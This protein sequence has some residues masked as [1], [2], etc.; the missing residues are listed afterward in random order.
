MYQIFIKIY[1]QLKKFFNKKKLTI[2]FLVIYVFSYLFHSL[3]YI[4]QSSVF[5]EDPISNNNLV[6]IFVEENLYSKIEDEIEWYAVD[7]VQQNIDNGRAI[8]FPINTD[9]EDGMKAQDIVKVLENIYFDGLDWETSSLIWLVLIWDI[10]LP[11]VENAGFVFPSIYPYVDFEEQQYIYNWN[12]D[13]FVSNNNPKWQAEVWHGILNFDEVQEYKDY[14]LKLTDYQS[15][16]VNYIGKRFWYDDFVAIKKYF[17]EIDINTYINNFLFTEDLAYR[18][19]TN[20]LADTFK[21]NYMD[22]VSAVLWWL[23]DLTRT[24][25]ITDGWDIFWDFT[26]WVNNY[27][28]DVNSLIDEA[29]FDSIAWSQVPTLMLEW[30]VAEFLKT[31]D[32]L[33]NPNYLVQMRDNVEAGWR[34][35]EE[36]EDWSWRS[37]LDSHIEKISQKDA[38]IINDLDSQLQPLIVEF[39]N[40]LEEA[41]DLQV[42][43]EK[44]YMYV[45]IP[46]AY[47]FV[48]HEIQERELIPRVYTARRCEVMSDNIYRSFYFG[49]DATAIFEAEDLTTYRWTYRNY[50]YEEL[51]WLTL[52]DIQDGEIPLTDIANLDLQNKSVWWSYGVLSTQIEANRGYNIDSMIEEVWLYS[53]EKIHENYVEECA[54]WFKIIWIKIFCKW[55]EI[56]PDLWND[57]DDP[58]DDSP[59]ESMTDFAMR[60]RWWA[61]SVNLNQGLL[62][63][64]I[65]EFIEYDYTQAWKTIYDIGWSKAIDDSEYDANSV[66]AISSYA[67]LIKT[68]DRY[69]DYLY[70]KHIDDIE[71][72]G[73]QIID[74]EEIEF[75]SVYEDTSNRFADSKEIYLA[76]DGTGYEIETWNGDIMDEECNGEYN[77]QN[78]YRYKLIDSRQKNI[79]PTPEQLWWEVRSDY[80]E[81]GVVY[82]S[83]IRILDEISYVKSFLVDS[84]ENFERD[85]W[86]NDQI[87]SILDVVTQIDSD[88]Q[89]F[90]NESFSSST[91]DNVINSWETSLQDLISNS[92]INQMKDYADSA[93]ISLVWLESSLQNITLEGIYQRILFLD[94]NIP[95]L[96]DW[97]ADI[98]SALWW[99]ENNLSSLENAYNQ[100]T[101]SLFNSIDWITDVYSSLDSKRDHLNALISSWTYNI[102]CSNWEK[103]DDLCDVVLDLMDAVQDDSSFNILINDNNVDTTWDVKTLVSEFYQWNI[104]ELGNFFIMEDEELV[105]IFDVLNARFDIVYDD[106]ELEI[107]D[108]NLLLEELDVINDA[109]E[110]LK[111]M[112]MTPLTKDRPI[113]SP[114]YLTFQ[115]LS[116]DIVRFIYPNLYHV[117]VFYED[118][119]RQRLK[120]VNEIKEAIVDYLEKLVEEYNDK[121]SNQSVNKDRYYD[122]HKEWFDFLDNVES[123]VTPNRSY[124]LIDDDYLSSFFD[125][126]TINLIANLLYYQNV[127]W[128][129]KISNNEIVDDIKQ[130]RLDF[131]VN[132][133]IAYIMSEY[134]KKDNDHGAILSPSYRADWYEVAFIN[135]DGKDYIQIWAV[136]D[137]VAD[138]QLLRSKFLASQESQQIDPP[139]NFQEEL[140]NECNVS[141]QWT[142]PLMEWPEA[143]WC[144][145]QKTIEKPLE[146]TVDFRDVQG[147]VFGNFLSEFTGTFASYGESFEMYGDEWIE[148]FSFPD[149]DNTP[150]EDL[151]NFPQNEYDVESNIEY[152]D[153][154]NAL[155]EEQLLEND[156]WWMMQGDADNLQDVSSFTQAELVVN[157]SVVGD[158]DA[159]IEISST[160]NVWDVDLQIKV[161]GSDCLAI[162]NISD[163]L[164]EDPYFLDEINLYENPISQKI[165]LS[166]NIAWVSIVQIQLCLPGDDNTCLV[167][168]QQLITVPWEVDD[169]SF[170]IFFA[171]DV[172][173]QGASQ[174]VIVH[175]YDRFWNQIGQVLDEYEL[176]VDAGYFFVQWNILTWVSFNNFDKANYLYYAPQET[177]TANVSLHKIRWDTWNYIPPQESID[178]VDGQ[179]RVRYDGG[180]LEWWNI[181]EYS[182]PGVV[183]EL[184]YTDIHN[185]YQVDKNNIP[186]LTLSFLTEDL[187]P[188]DA[189]LTVKSK[190]W[191]F[192]IWEIQTKVRP[193]QFNWER[194]DVLQNSFVKKKSFHLRNGQIDIY[195]Y[196][197]FVAGEDIIT[198]EIPWLDLINI[199]V[200]IH[201]WPARVV[202]LTLDKESLKEWEEVFASL[203]IKDFRENVLDEDL[204][205]D[206][207]LAGSLEF[208]DWDQSMSLVV[209]DWIYSDLRILARDVGGA[210][211][212]TAYLDEDIS[213]LELQMPGFAEVLVQ[214]DILPT[215]DLNVM[216]LNLFGSDWW[217]QRWYFSENNKFVHNLMTWS[218]KLLAVTTQ[219]FEPNKLRA[220]DII[221]WEDAQISNFWN[222]DILFSNSIDWSYQIVFENLALMFFDS[223]FSLFQNSWTKISS[224]TEENIFTNSKDSIL[225]FPEIL[226]SFVTQNEVLDGKLIVNGEIIF[227][228]DQKYLHPDLIVSY[229]I[230]K[231]QWY[232][233]WDLVWWEYE[234]G[235]FILWT[236]S[237]TFINDGN[238]FSH[239]V[240][241]DEAYQKNIV[242][243]EGSSNGKKWIWFYLTDSALSSNVVWYDSIESSKDPTLWVGFLWDFKNITLFG[244]GKTVGEATLPYSSHALINIWDPLLKKIDINETVVDTDF[245]SGNGEIIY[246][247]TDKSIFKVLPIDFN[248]DGLED[249]IVAHT[250]WTIKILKNYWWEQA[251][252]PL[253]RLMLL[254]VGI[255]NIE[256]WDVD[257]NGYEDILIWT[258]QDSLRVYTNDKWIFDVDGYPVCLN[259]NTLPWEINEFPE[260]FSDV[261]QIYFEYMDEDIDDQDK[262]LDIVTNDKFGDVKIFYWWSIDGRANYLSTLKYT[263]DEHRY[264]GQNENTKLIKNYS[265]RINEDWSIVQDQS[266]IHWSW[267]EKPNPVP[268]S[269][270]D[271]DIPSNP[272]LVEQIWG[273]TDDMD[274]DG[275]SADEIMNHLMSEW[276]LGAANNFDA[277]EVVASSASDMIRYTYTPVPNIPYYENISLDKLYYVSLEHLEDSD[278]ILAYKVY[279]DL[280]GGVLLDGD[281]VKITITLESKEDNYF[282]YID[283]VLWPWT[284]EE[285]QNG[286][287]R[288][289][290]LLVY[291]YRW[292]IFLYDR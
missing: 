221:V 93:N 86:T 33:L 217:N 167:K 60:N 218:E 271:D 43:D 180:V 61:S 67:S 76:S 106:L 45:P 121:I 162:N 28:N 32:T 169:S 186:N 127:P 146:L 59:W 267:L 66:D 196:P 7:Y 188:L 47:Q 2:M 177:L 224:N 274:F 87:Q 222:K 109:D 145:L 288:L 112:S 65:Y 216:Y 107:I 5:A 201:P 50:S 92:Q 57:E 114:R 83:Y 98:D 38:W 108:I 174:P 134:L 193:V 236:D 220:I 242:F 265:T 197:N 135:S 245:D 3:I 25:E 268:A 91:S 1:E 191:N 247:S 275:M 111:S 181:L 290:S 208:A 226:D 258:T 24:G 153:Q 289:Y 157:N 11:V 165:K 213:P 160:R 214:K 39:N 168:T 90:L 194:I 154:W 41:V 237:D 23:N 219:L 18:R 176:R 280:D 89:W 279:E 155:L 52:D 256:V 128:E 281:E 292:L 82:N 215:E 164:C 46:T 147:P 40:M 276:P 64:N 253:Q 95:L 118:N 264:V 159:S 80:I 116:W 77:I 132:A 171:M 291:C 250:D 97:L 166:N 55:K 223:N 9:S 184:A 235:S 251:F 79:S 130:T 102:G 172:L 27:V 20:T 124:Q 195:L 104:I 246:T 238:I 34:W 232:T 120:D 136:P 244:Q 35:Y 4:N 187:V 69:Q 163:N 10:P 182:L 15:D 277:N 16:P 56:N 141:S 63:D 151:E 131:D 192:E 158:F 263:C 170:E 51:E 260:D 88:I 189:W 6:A 126:D 119:W 81:G 202:S 133:K 29:D 266:L 152:L 73:K 161:V 103:Y 261:Y 210:G 282:S 249:M 137:F 204:E 209:H 101:L 84:T 140:Q 129:E 185:L 243:A 241:Q 19:Y 36:N 68:H 122:L 230:S 203:E 175:A 31:Y 179:L 62:Q 225:Y 254:A 22:G 207:Q 284:F 149:P 183:T 72:W 94:P 178:I 85:G 173:Q 239:I 252:K 205:V 248:N 269:S 287:L 283:R 156:L 54:K 233:L 100:N 229:S 190:N 123:L 148:L 227:D 17:S 206:I 257:G 99:L 8:I 200:V 44:Y 273:N 150:P 21:W 49:R 278:P 115:W 228:P 110:M 42:E 143:F 53:W 199:P 211:Y 71:Q 75:F 270:D 26:E 138:I 259:I 70:P 234:I 240:L 117:E 231:L 74:Y 285:E 13:F 58:E 14:F 198:I 105:N 255:K 48:N 12:K 139:T 262:T 113:D 37:A 125:E 96:S 78:K 144:W 30:I 142:V 212:V 272:G 286:M